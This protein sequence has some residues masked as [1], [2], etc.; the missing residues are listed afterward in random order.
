MFGYSLTKEKNVK[1]SLRWHQFRP[2]DKDNA[3]LCDE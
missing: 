2:T 3:Y 1:R